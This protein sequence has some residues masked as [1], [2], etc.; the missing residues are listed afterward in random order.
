L[1]IISLK[2]DISRKHKNYVSINCKEATPFAQWLKK[3][4]NAISKSHQRR[5]MNI[6]G[7]Y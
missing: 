4:S 7:D 3:T 6:K 5:I 2:E 1:K